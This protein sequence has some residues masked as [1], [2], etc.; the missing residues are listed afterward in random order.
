MNEMLL[1]VAGLC[2]YS[3]NNKSHNYTRYMTKMV[4]DQI[5]RLLEVRTSLNHFVIAK[6]ADKHFGDTVHI[7][8]S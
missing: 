8:K 6:D 7:D 4:S 1:I 2:V 3:A 5:L